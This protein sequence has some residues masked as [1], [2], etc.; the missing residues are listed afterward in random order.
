[1][2]TKVKIKKIE[3][4]VSNVPINSPEHRIEEIKREIIEGSD[5]EDTMKVEVFEMW[6]SDG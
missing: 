2:E 5:D 4:T 6:S 1:M 3:D